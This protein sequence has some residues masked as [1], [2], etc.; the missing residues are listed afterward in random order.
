MAKL[1]TF[2]FQHRMHS[3]LRSRYLRLAAGGGS[4]MATGRVQ[5][6]GSVNRG[7]EDSQ[8]LLG[9]DGDDDDDDPPLAPWSPSNTPRSPTILL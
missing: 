6:R 3:Q 1:I 9:K 4:V 2:L 8:H 7:E 5:F